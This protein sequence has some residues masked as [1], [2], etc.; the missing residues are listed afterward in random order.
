VQ[1][2]S[3]TRQTA[4]AVE[5]V[6]LSEAKAHLRV[7]TSDD[8]TY[9]GTLITAAREWVEQY[10]DR[11]LIHTQWVLRF[12]KFP[13][14]GIEPVELP[15]PPMVTS[16]TATAVA[17]T[18]TSEAGT[19]STYSTAE[20]RVD[21]NATPGAILPIYGSTWTPHR[22]DDNAISVTWWAGYGAS[23]S[24]VPAAIRHA[25][26]MLIGTWY[27]RRASA[28]NAGGSEVPFGV[29]SLLDSQRWG[30]YR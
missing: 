17:V 22:Q 8:D 4:P 6:T 20:Y 18:F 23:G 5:P 14:S 2:R 19:T 3:L 25:M 21:R 29:K 26:L 30:S 24:S 10:L 15:R 12:D 27:E 16:G 11:T 9:I 7:D 1:Y 13:P 28:D